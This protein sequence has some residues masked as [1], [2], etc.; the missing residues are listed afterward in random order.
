MLSKHTTHATCE[1]TWDPDPYHQI[2]ID[3]WDAYQAGLDAFHAEW[4]RNDPSRKSGYVYI[5][6]MWT[7][8]LNIH[9]HTRL[10]KIGMSRTPEKRL[11]EIQ[12][13]N[14]KMPYT[15]RLWRTFW[16]PDMV[17][18]ERLLH[19]LMQRYRLDGEW[20]R[21]P[22]DIGEAI[23]NIWYIAPHHTLTEL[24]FR[25][26]FDGGWYTPQAFFEYQVDQRKNHPFRQNGDS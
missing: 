6:D 25:E 12:K 26:S 19:M 22:Y 21:L 16:S 7:N 18:A 14:V 8:D 15:I 11:K 17:R 13:S 5:M 20:F 4:V 24:E 23:D 2:R 9:E 1:H 3:L 10:T